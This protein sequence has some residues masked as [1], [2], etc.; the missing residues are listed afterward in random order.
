[1]KRR[2]SKVRVDPHELNRQS[3]E[4]NEKLRTEGPRM[5]AIAA[6]LAWRTDKNG[7][8]EDFDITIL[9]PRKA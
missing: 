6:W 5:N 2:Q 1:M 3:E 9:T 8:G 7:F 4:I